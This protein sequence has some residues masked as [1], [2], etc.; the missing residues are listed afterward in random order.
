MDIDLTRLTGMSAPVLA[1]MLAAVLAALVMA[2]AVHLTSRRQHG[3]M[4]WIFYA[5]LL[6]VAASS[7]LSGRD[8]SSQTLLAESALAAP[9]RP[10]LLALV[11]PLISLLILLVCGERIVSHW[12]LRQKSPA[13]HSMLIAFVIFWVSTVAVPALWGANPQFSHDYGYPLVIGLAAALATGAERD[14]SLKA[15]RNAMLLVMLLGWL[16]LPLK[17]G[18][19]LDRAYTQGLLPGLP[20]F[21][22][23]ASHPVSM[24]LL[25]QLGL[26]CLLA[27]PYERRWLNRLAWAT[28][29]LTLFMAQSKT[30]W[31]AFLLCSGAMLAVQHGPGLWRRAADPMRPG[32]GIATLSGL[33][34]LLSVLLGVLLLGEME[35]RVSRFFSS[36][37]GAQLAS[38][39]GRDR[40]WAIAWDEWRRNPVFGYGPGLWDEQFRASIAMPSATHAH[41]QFMD[42]LSRSGTVGASGLALYAAVLLFMSVRFAKATQGLS[43]GLFVALALRAISEVPLLMFG[44]GPELVIHVLLLMV[45]AAASRQTRTANQASPT[46]SPVLDPAHEYRGGG[47]AAP[48]AGRARATRDTCT[49]RDELSAHKPFNAS[50]SACLTP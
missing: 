20:R 23:L 49:S 36:P 34:L 25:A 40:I 46:P 33:M 41:N 11:Q 17:P 3:F 10:P 48:K 8:L 38:M 29:L 31:L 16:L 5:M 37:E 19:V 26:L 35:S 13:P 9:A 12:L 15:V 44:Y 1:G 42:T 14:Q 43:L 50:S 7:L 30:A 39:T 32:F 6:V 2:A 18:L 22:G 47:F 28:G 45:L 21:G 27:R 24:G 4:H